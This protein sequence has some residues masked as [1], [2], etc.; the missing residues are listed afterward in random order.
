[1]WAAWE[2]GGRLP[3]AWLAM[4]AAAV[5]LSRG[6]QGDGTGFTLWRSRAVGVARVD[7]AAESPLLAAFAD[8]RVAVHSGMFEAAETLVARAFAPFPDGRFGAYARAAGAELAVAAGSA[9]AADRLV[10]AGA[11]ENDWALACVARATGRLHGDPAAFAAAIEGFR[12]L[13]ARFEEDATLALRR[14]SVRATRG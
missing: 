7:D 4:P 8:A 2:R 5:A 3:A 14:A 1:M 11:A 10:G 9:D 13:G 6:L 12:A